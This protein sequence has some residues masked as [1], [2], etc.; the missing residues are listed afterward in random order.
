MFNNNFDIL[1]ILEHF[2]YDM[3][4]TLTVPLFPVIYW[5]QSGL[6]RD[7]ELHSI[8]L[9]FAFHVIPDV[10]AVVKV[11]VVAVVERPCST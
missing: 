2:E 1:R 3:S 7:N 11:N 9:T 8:W 4:P 5:L 6:P 10:E